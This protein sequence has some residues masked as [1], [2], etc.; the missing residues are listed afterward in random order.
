[1]KLVEVVRTLSTPTRPTDGRRVVSRH[2]ETV[3]TTGDTTASSSTRLLRP[4]H[5]R[6]GPR[7]EQGIASRDDIDNA[8]KLGC[9]YRWPAPAR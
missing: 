7:L 4:L 5:A 2:R 9:G 6:C 1:M 3:V 8:M